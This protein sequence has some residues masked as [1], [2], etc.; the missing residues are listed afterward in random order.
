MERQFRRVKRYRDLTLLKQP[1]RRALTP[2]TIA[3]GKPRQA[4]RH[5]NFNFPGDNPG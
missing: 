3:R 1:L 5:L 2:T 4:R